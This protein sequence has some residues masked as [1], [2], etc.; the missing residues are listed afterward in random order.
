MN[1]SLSGNRPTTLVIAFQY[2]VTLGA[3]Y[4]T[5][6]TTADTRKPDSY[7]RNIGGRGGGACSVNQ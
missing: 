2:L 4:R 6:V 3:I 7:K 1:A 5:D